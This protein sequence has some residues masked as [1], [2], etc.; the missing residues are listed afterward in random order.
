VGGW[1]SGHLMYLLTGVACSGKSTIAQT[2]AKD[3]AGSNK[4]AASFFFSR[5]ILR[6]SD[7]SKVILTLAYQLAISIP[8]MQELIKD[9]FTADPSIPDKNMTVQFAKL[10]YQPILP[11]EPLVFRMIV[12]IDALDQCEDRDGAVKLIH[13]IT[14]AVRAENIFPLH[15]FFTS[16]PEVRIASA[17]VEQTIMLKTCWLALGDFDSSDETKDD[18]IAHPSPH[19]P[20]R[21]RIPFS[22]VKLI[23]PSL[24]SK[25]GFAM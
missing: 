9:A 23:S 15:F 10:V 7:M 22:S 2:L 18:E 11:I 13:V 21:G 17:F 12:V 5:R 8:A 1:N 14:G 24:R 25:L 4:L 19:E 3:C 16:R 6:C 20:V